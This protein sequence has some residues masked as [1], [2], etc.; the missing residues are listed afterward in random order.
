MLRRTLT[1]LGAAAAAI[2]LATSLASPAT[3]G[4]AGTVLY[5]GTTIPIGRDVI[6]VPGGTLSHVINGSGRSVS[7]ES[8]V[9]ASTQICYGR[10]DFTTRKSGGLAYQRSSGST[11]QGCMT[12]QQVRNRYNFSYDSVVRQGCAEIRINGVVKGEQC[13]WIS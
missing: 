12:Y 13:H 2:A 11:Y 10:I 4:A 3:A 8:A 6:S 9:A 5:G 1:T 7:G